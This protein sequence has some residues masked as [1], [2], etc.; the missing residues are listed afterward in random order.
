MCSMQI[1]NNNIQYFYYKFQ[2]ADKFLH[3]ALV[4]FLVNILF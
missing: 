2:I 4:N 1:T 3:N